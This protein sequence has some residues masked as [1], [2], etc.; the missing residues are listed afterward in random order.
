ME[1]PEDFLERVDNLVV[2]ERQELNEDLN[3][4]FVLSQEVQVM[5][6][7]FSWRRLYSFPVQSI[8]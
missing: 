3:P 6:G 7:A 2:K 8:L 4:A 5:L 1:G